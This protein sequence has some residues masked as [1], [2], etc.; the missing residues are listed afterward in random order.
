MP[1][2]SASSALLAVVQ[3]LDSRNIQ[4]K[5]AQT[6]DRRPKPAIQP[7]PPRP[8]N[9]NPYDRSSLRGPQAFPSA[10]A[11]A[12]KTATM[13]AVCFG[14]QPELFKVASTL[15]LQRCDSEAQ[16]HGR[17]WGAGRHV[18][19]HAVQ[20]VGRLELSTHIT[21]KPTNAA[22]PTQFAD[23]L[24]RVPSSATLAGPEACEPCAM[25]CCG[26]VPRVPS[27]D[28]IK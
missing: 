1:Q 21:H 14:E 5:G 12:A 17:L 25:D 24:K 4:A 20:R 11:T 28:Y 19:S 9:P 26:G 22:P 10:Q 16:V 23:F 2:V 6:S 13:D 27:L 3:K 15:S 8:R 7:Q 18:A